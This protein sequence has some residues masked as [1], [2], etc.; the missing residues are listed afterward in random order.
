MLVTQLAQLQPQ[1]LQKTKLPPEQLHGK[2]AS[3][4]NQLPDVLTISSQGWEILSRKIETNDQIAL[5]RPLEEGQ[6]GRLHNSGKLEASKLTVPT[7]D[8]RQVIRRQR[9]TTKSTQ[10]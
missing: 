2:G 8:C 5:V 6:K 9:L 1:P 10:D 3:G 7:T 4:T